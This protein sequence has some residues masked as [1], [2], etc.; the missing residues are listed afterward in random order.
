M[1]FASFTCFSKE[2]MCVLLLLFWKAAGGIW[3]PYRRTEAVGWEDTAEGG[4]AGASVSAWGER[5]CTQ[6]AGLVQKQPGVFSVE[7]VIQSVLSMFV[8]PWW[9]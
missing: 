2:G 7:L 4:E 1:F 6:S 9:C 3:K 5:I 8:P